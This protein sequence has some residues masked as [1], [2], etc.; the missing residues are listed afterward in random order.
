MIEIKCKNLTV[1][2]PIHDSIFKTEYIRGIIDVSVNIK[3]GEKVAI[4][5]KNG[6][7]KSTFL[8]TLSGVY[9]SKIGSLEIIP[10]VKTLYDLS[11]GLDLD[12]DGYE[13]I[14]LLM[15]VHDIAL[16]KYQSVVEYVVNFTEL[17]DYLKRPVRIFSAGMKLRFLFS[18][19]TFKLENEILIIDEIVNVGDYYFQL[20]AQERIKQI[21]NNS[22]ILIIASHAVQVLKKY[23]ERGL[24]FSDGKIVF[25]G[26][27]DDSIMFYE[28]LK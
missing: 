7:G 1:E 2:Y 20:K 25:D 16:S 9:K 22:G 17:G 18:I 15:T 24:V 10:N 3:K 23:C 5:G 19:F 4:L 6:S 13:N 8:K 14:K 28:N 21:I 11:N 26:Q 27:I 12:A